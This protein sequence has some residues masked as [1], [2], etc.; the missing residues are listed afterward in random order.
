MQKLFSS[1]LNA[2]LG[3]VEFNGKVFAEGLLPRDLQKNGIANIDLALRDGSILDLD[4][5]P[6]R[7]L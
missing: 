3:D 1:H 5:S 7:A 4:N 6:L 2:A